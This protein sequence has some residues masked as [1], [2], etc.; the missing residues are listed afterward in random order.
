MAAILSQPRCDILNSL[1]LFG[2]EQLPEQ[3]L[4]CQLDPWKQILGKAE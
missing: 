1:W 4:Y 2:T 3:M